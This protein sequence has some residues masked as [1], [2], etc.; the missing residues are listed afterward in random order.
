MLNFKTELR[1]N[2]HSS[3]YIYVLLFLPGVQVCLFRAYFRQIWGYYHKLQIWWLKFCSF[4][5]IF[6]K[7]HLQHSWCSGQNTMFQHHSRA[8]SCCFEIT[9]HVT[10]TTIVVMICLTQLTALCFA[11]IG[12]LSLVPRCFV[13]LRIDRTVLVC[14]PK[15]IPSYVSVLL[16]SFACGPYS[17][18]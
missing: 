7:T 13:M 6:E 16:M 14:Y 10:T 18:F 3:L 11:F 8:Q 9:R 15:P 1:L 2:K 12:S 5:F 4:F 17:D